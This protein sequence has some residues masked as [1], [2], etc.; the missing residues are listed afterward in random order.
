MANTATRNETNLIRKASFGFQ[1][2]S[3]GA[4]R[5]YNP[6]IGLVPALNLC[7]SSLFGSFD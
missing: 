3:P 6:G 7:A 1:I 4:F 5:A 2:S